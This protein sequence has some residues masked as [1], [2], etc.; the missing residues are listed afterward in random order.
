MNKKYYNQLSE[1][2]VVSLKLQ[3][4]ILNSNEAKLFEKEDF[5]KEAIKL[6]K[7]DEAAKKIGIKIKDIIQYKELLKKSLK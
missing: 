3:G 7:F 4:G 1:A 6:R 5:F 2:S